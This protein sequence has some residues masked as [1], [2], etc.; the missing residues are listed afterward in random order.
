MWHAAPRL[1]FI[2]VHKKRAA[3]PA[4]I[5]LKL[6]NAQQMSCIKRT[7]NWAANAKGQVEIHW[8][9]VQETVNSWS[10]VDIS[11]GEFHPYRTTKLWAKKHTY[12]TNCSIDRTEP[13]FKKLTA[14]RQNRLSQISPIVMKFTNALGRT[15]VT[16][17]IFTKLTLAG[18]LFVKSP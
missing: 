7:P 3:F 8:G 13:T 11:R 4:P 6:T 5:C 18:N 14:S 2:D 10:F 15:T 16:Q 9:D 1:P 12:V 17:R